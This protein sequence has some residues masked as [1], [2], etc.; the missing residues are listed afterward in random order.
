MGSTDTSTGG[1]ATAPARFAALDGWRGI[2]ACLVV[3]FHAHGYSPL[4][5][6]DLIHHSFLFV[7]FFFV[8]SGFVIAYTYASRLDTWHGTRRFLLLRIGRVYPLHLFM[9]LL[10]VA[11]ELAL[12]LKGRT[13]GIER[14]AFTGGNHPLAILSNLFL[15]QSLNIHDSLTWN[16]PAW[17]ISTEFWTYVLFALASLWLGMRHW[18][19]LLAIVATAVLLVHLSKSG[20]DTT[21]DY[22]L[23]RC[24]LGF[25][26]GI[27]CFRL[28][29]L[30]TRAMKGASTAAITVLELLVVVGVVAFVSGVGD[31]PWQ[32]AAPFVFAL[33][34]LV[35]ALEGGLLSRL[36]QFRLLNWIGMLSYSIYLTHAFIV[37]LLPRIIKAVTRLDLWTPM[38]LHD[39]T[40]VMAY[41]R[42]DIEGTLFY[43]FVLLVTIGFSALTYRWVETPGREWTRRWVGRSKAPGAAAAHVNTPPLAD[44]STTSSQRT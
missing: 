2:C 10:F 11:F 31:S 26:L 13:P 7:D 40:V 1:N 15:V 36:F 23:I 8:L 28:H 5:R 12:M 25:A 9:L 34:V 19:V 30:W 44:V 33:A 41:G 21:Y 38:P 3:F 22:G 35:F 42:N 17:S 27:A 4:Y 43:A 24:V 16:G 14:E 32:F 18:V 37:M 6:S 20:M 39:G 29:P